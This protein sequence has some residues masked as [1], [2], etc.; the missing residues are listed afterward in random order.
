MLLN[1]KCDFLSGA[2][3]IDV[4]DVFAFETIFHGGVEIGQFFLE[5]GVVVEFL[6][7]A[8][9][10]PPF[11]RHFGWNVEYNGEVWAQ[12]VGVDSLKPGNGLFA[13]ART[14]GLIGDGGVVVTVADDVD[15]IHEIGA[16][17][18]V[19]VVHSVSGKH[20]CHGG[21]VWGAGT[22]DTGNH[23]T[24]LDHLPNQ[25]SDGSV[26]GFP[27]GMHG[28]T[29]AAEVV[30]QIFGVGGGARPVDPFEYDEISLDHGAK[31]AA[32]R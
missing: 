6:D 23:D 11:C 32:E 30:P 7:S 15:S 19:H 21:P 8:A 2:V 9:L 20:E 14:D 25:Y 16:D 27:G 31:V 13:L 22:V 18:R 28:Q 26:A 1:L 17:L 5:L 24:A 12:R 3:P 29:T 10:P 4:H